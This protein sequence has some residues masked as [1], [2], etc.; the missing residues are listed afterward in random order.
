M[1]MIVM[2]M[3]MVTTIFLPLTARQPVITE[4]WRGKCDW[5]L[6]IMA[7]MMMVVVV[8]VS[9]VQLGQSSLSEN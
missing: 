2:M 7:K 5:R 3:V 9:F 4:V 8:V 1:M 6:F